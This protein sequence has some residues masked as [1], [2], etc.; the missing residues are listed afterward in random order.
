MKQ[1]Q[2]DIG[3]IG[4]KLK[5]AREAKGVSVS[6][7]AA[8]TKILSKFIEAM[9]D[10]MNDLV[11][12]AS[13]SPPADQ[14]ER[15]GSWLSSIPRDDVID[16]RLTQEYRDF[17][18]AFDRLGQAHRRV[19]SMNRVNNSSSVLDLPSYNLFT[20]NI[21][22]TLEQ[23]FPID[24]NFLQHS[25]SDD[26]ILRIFEFLECHSLIQMCFTCSRMKQLAYRSATQRTYDV[27]ITR[28]LRSAMQLLRAKEQIDGVGNG[29]HDNHVRVPIL[30]LSRRIL[31]TNSGD[32]EYNGLYFCTGSNGNG[33][34]FT[35]PRFPERR[36]HCRVSTT[37]NGHNHRRQETIVN[38]ATTGE[39][40]PVARIHEANFHPPNGAAGVAQEPMGEDPASRFES[41]M[42]QP[43]QLL[44]CV[45]AKRFSNEVRVRSLLAISTEVFAH[46][47]FWIKDD[48]LVFQQG[49]GTIRDTS[50][51]CNSW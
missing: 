10:D 9:E 25:T 1:T 37:V 34:V 31:V 27:A 20:R 30:L 49:G 12:I 15:C 42:A 22:A 35:K 24:K 21:H 36:V 13:P 2:L 5:S 18:L 40:P 32:P 45:I 4:Q 33:F 43:G 39:Q 11:E 3:T 51:R 38:G 26:V 50:W 8:S 23:F 44:R 48:S 7:A 16:L 28:Q 17:L 14:L 29:I 47:F 19:I 46:H 6:E 41:E